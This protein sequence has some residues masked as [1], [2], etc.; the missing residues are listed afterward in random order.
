[1]KGRQRDVSI[2]RCGCCGRS[3]GKG[4]KQERCEPLCEGSTAA[5]A[6]ILNHYNVQAPILNHYNVQH[7]QATIGVVYVVIKAWLI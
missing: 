7:A 3:R 5:A 4:C 1:M 6:L 2:A